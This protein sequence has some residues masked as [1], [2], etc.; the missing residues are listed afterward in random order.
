MIAWLMLASRTSGRSAWM[1]PNLFATLFYG[2]EAYRNEYLRS[3]WAGLALIVFIYGCAGALWGLA[4]RESRPRFL[5][6]T[7]AVTGLAV[8][9]VFFRIVWLHAAPLLTLYAPDRQ[10]E[11]GHIL[12]GLALARSPEF[13]RRIALA[14]GVYA[15]EEIKSGEVIV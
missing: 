6:A 10:L 12:W 3:S 7:G 14:T 2:T 15:P 5:A 13:A 11:F 9:Y 1:V 8:F 4:V